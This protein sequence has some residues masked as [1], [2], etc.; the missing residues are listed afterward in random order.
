MRASTVASS[1]GNGA[2]IHHLHF[3]DAQGLREKLSG[4][5]GAPQDIERAKRF[6]PDGCSVGGE[7]HLIGRRRQVNLFPSTSIA[8]CVRGVSPGEMHY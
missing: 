3:T 2:L 1:S 4:H 8:I 7:L 6:R 5:W